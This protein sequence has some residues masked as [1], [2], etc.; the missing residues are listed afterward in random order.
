M[1]K[2]K[3]TITVS[4]D[5]YDKLEKMAQAM[6]LTKNSLCTYVIANHVYVSNQM[7][8]NNIANLSNDNSN[9]KSE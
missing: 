4:D 5:L 2:K 3:I 1:S 8:T 9:N 7:L 6:G